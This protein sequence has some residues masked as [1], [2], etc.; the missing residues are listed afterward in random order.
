[1]SEKESKE[2][3]K[4]KVINLKNPQSTIKDRLEKRLKELK[5]DFDAGQ[6]EMQKL[7][8]RRLEL[9][10]VLLRI[11]GAIKVLEEELGKKDEVK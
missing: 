10:R 5:V 11:D 3:S 6:K 9:P 8:A 4:G 1:M 2:G 7:E